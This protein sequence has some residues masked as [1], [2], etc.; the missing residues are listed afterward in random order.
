MTTQ[1]DLEAAILAMHAYNSGDSNFHIN[2]IAS[3]NIGDYDFRR[4]FISTADYPNSGFS[5]TAF[6]MNSGTSDGTIILSIRGTNPENLTDVQ[7]GY[8]IGAGQS[9][10]FSPQMLTAIQAYQ[11]LIRGDEDFYNAKVELTGHSLGG[12]IAGYL[13]SIYGQ[14]ATIFNNMPYYDAAGKD[15]D[16]S[17]AYPDRGLT[18][19]LYHGDGIKDLDTS[20]ITSYATTGEFLGALRAI[21]S[22]PNV[23]YLDSYSGLHNP[24]AL[25]SMALQVSLQWASYTG[26]EQWHSFGQSLWDAYLGADVAATISQAG[27]MVGTGG[28]ASTV[29]QEAIAY[30]AI[31]SGDLVFGNTAIYAMFNDATDVA[32]AIDQDNSA[33]PSATVSDTIGKI[34]V[35]YAGYLAINEV[36]AEEDGDARDG[37]VR[38]SSSKTTLSVSFSNADW[39]FSGKQELSSF[40]LDLINAQRDDPAF[41]DQLLQD[42]R[43]YSRH[44]QAAE[45]LLDIITSV[46]YQVAANPTVYQAPN[47]GLDLLFLQ[48]GSIDL[49]GGTGE[50]V[51]HAVVGSNESTLF[52]GGNGSDITIGGTGADTFTGS[53]GNDVIDGGDGLSAAGVSD[54]TVNY[55]KSP[56]PVNITIKF[57]NNLDFS[58]YTP[59]I[60]VKDGYGSTDSLESI[61]RI[62]GTS[63][64]DTVAIVG[65]IDSTK[66]LLI[67]AHGGQGSSPRDSIDLSGTWSDTTVTIDRDGSGSI[68]SAD[69]GHIDLTNFH[70]VIKASSYNDTITD[71][72]SG[73]KW[74]DGGYGIDT[75]TIGDDGGTILGGRGW[76]SDTLTGGAGDDVIAGGRAADTLIGGAG[77]DLL[78]GGEISYGDETLDGGSGDDKLLVIGSVYGGTITLDGGEGNDL[79]QS[80]GTDVDAVYGPTIVFGAGS[81]HDEIL[82]SDIRPTGLNIQYIDAT[83][84]DISDVELIWDATQVG[85]SDPDGRRH[86]SGDIALKIKSTGDT[87]LIR[88]VQG[89]H[90]PYQQYD[91]SVIH[92]GNTTYGSVHLGFLTDIKFANDRSLIIGDGVINVDLRIGSV[93]AFDLALS[94]FA[95][96]RE[97]LILVGSDAE[98][99]YSGSSGNDQIATG[100]GNDEVEMS[101]GNDV[102][103]GGDGVDTVFG[104]GSADFYHGGTT[105]GGQLLMV[106][107]RTSGQSI[108]DNVEKMDFLFKEGGSHSDAVSIVTASAQA[109]V[110]VVSAQKE[111]IALGD[112]DDIVISS[113]TGD[114]IYGGSGNDEVQYQLTSSGFRVYFDETGSVTVEDSSFGHVIWYEG[115]PTDADQ[116]TGVERVSFS[117]DGQSIGIEDLAALGSE[118]GD[119][120]VGTDRSEVLFGR[121]GDD[122][123]VS[124]AG[125]DRLYGGLGNDTFVWGVGDGNDIIEEG[126]GEYGG[127]EALDLSSLSLCDVQIEYLGS[128]MRITSLN[129]GEHIDVTNQ[130]SHWSNDNPSERPGISLFEFGVDVISF[131]DV[132]LYREEITQ[133]FLDSNWF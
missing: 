108:L 80:N 54:D 66:S 27:T 97:G 59:G 53:K 68:S 44:N 100:S 46:S 28:S 96:G 36:T 111:L 32:K 133:S 29:V 99:Y 123:L 43:V 79:Y 55:S 106:D 89:D 119:M 49:G 128:M 114:R 48:S 116:L 74:I 14:K 57:Y 124:G 77:S 5:A 58:Y 60:E 51:N 67:D 2:G 75:I 94:G 50:S 112:G 47:S 122:I 130:F 131:S 17:V 4:S 109:D 73:D 117:V 87:I 1:H 110:V 105:S 41:W 35:E 86:L 90:R 104:Y 7:G 11:S 88:D 65:A 84:V 113:V 125:A 10:I 34:I 22:G 21:N 39:A 30:S 82:Y 8:A 16:D 62:I 129:S 37:V 98:D 61:E 83:S 15:H 12:G 6:V 91:P 93:D 52:L 81:G 40:K 120:I 72:S 127:Y 78:I 71:L 42:L 13:A 64:R 63:G 102:I 38:L 70:T 107:T 132:T 76:Y 126:V 33:A 24:L 18:N 115:V 69:G 85:T 31:L 121:G 9:A 56:A 3:S 95:A 92:Q 26:N 23:T 103:N 19:Y 25:H 118:D 20:E 101:S 45:N